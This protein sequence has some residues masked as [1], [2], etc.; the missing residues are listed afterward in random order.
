MV[1]DAAN[2]VIVDKIAIGDGCDGVAFDAV[3][4]NIY[5]SNGSDGTMTV[6]HE[7]NAAKFTVLENVATKRGARTIA[8]DKQTHLIYQQQN[9]KRL[10]P[11]KK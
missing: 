1:I 9:L 8:L 4:K 6:I 2:G 10:I 11:I 7:E 3:T 5:T